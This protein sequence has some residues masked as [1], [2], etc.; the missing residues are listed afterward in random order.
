M[1]YIEPF[2]DYIVLLNG[3]I[4]QCIDDIGKGCYIFLYKLTEDYNKIEIPQQQDFINLYNLAK[5][6][7]SNTFSVNTEDIENA[8]LEEFLDVVNAYLKEF[9]DCHCFH[10]PI[11]VF[12]KITSKDIIS[13]FKAKTAIVVKG[14]EEFNFIQ[15]DDLKNFEY[16]EPNQVKDSYENSIGLRLDC[17]TRDQ[18]NKIKNVLEQTPQEEVRHKRFQS[19]DCK[20]PDFIEVIP[21]K[22]VEQFILHR[23]FIDTSFVDSKEKI[24]TGKED[25]IILDLRKPD[26]DIMKLMLQMG[27][28]EE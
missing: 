6:N 25:K 19:Y 20:Y 14:V 10:P 13:C 28:I 5:Q 17:K 27:I 26:Q 1:K 3:D 16:Y 15:E 4:V 23:Q 11:F 12:K 21:K 24:F 9:E 22:Y 2:R 8:S 7:G 18:V